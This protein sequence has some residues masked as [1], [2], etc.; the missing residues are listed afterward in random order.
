MRNILGFFFILR[1]YSAILFEEKVFGT[2]G[3][4]ILTQALCIVPHLKDL[5]KK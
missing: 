5:D 3:F 2:H 1:P 4:E